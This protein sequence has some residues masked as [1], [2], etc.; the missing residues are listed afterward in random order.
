MWRVG[1]GDLDIRQMSRQLR[2]V[3]VVVVVVVVVCI[4]VRQG[5]FV[6]IPSAS[7]IFEVLIARSS[8]GAGW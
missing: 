6:D 8:K 7:W 4:I 3:V 1:V 5:S 2:W